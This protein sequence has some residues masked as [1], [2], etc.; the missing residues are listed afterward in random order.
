MTTEAF[1]TAHAVLAEAER[2]QNS[3]V[4]ISMYPESSLPFPKQNKEV[5]Y[6]AIFGDAHKASNTYLPSTLNKL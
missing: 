6:R 3:Y 2:R 1:P 4:F 5:H